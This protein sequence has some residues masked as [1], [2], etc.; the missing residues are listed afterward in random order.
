MVI[1]VIAVLAVA[2]VVVYKINSTGGGSSNSS[3]PTGSPN[4][5]GNTSSS[6]VATGSPDSG[7]RPSRSSA[8]YTVSLNGQTISQGSYVLCVAD[9]PLSTTNT[10]IVTG[11]QAESTSPAVLSV[12]GADTGVEM[13][14]DTGA[15]WQSW[16]QSSPPSTNTVTLTGRTYKISGT[17]VLLNG[18]GSATGPVPFEVEATCP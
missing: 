5:E 10:R 14:L 17:A 7:E 15:I 8:G 3:A 13:H 11:T 12:D 9:E 16:R 18:V 4:T 6:S 2:A 1:A